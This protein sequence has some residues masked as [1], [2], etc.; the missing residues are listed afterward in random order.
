MGY[1][2][3][4][5]YNKQK[6]GKIIEQIFALLLLFLMIFLGA[7]AYRKRV[8]IAKWLKA[9]TTAT[10]SKLISR[11]RYLERKIEDAQA[12]IDTID[13]IENK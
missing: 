9:P 1:P 3:I 7:F 2:A 12:E 8:E 11:K 4:A 10:Q 13:E 5:K 6:G